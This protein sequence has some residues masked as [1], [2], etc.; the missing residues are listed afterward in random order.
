MGIM[1]LCL[2]AK[3][4]LESIEPCGLES[5]V[6]LDPW[7]CFHQSSPPSHTLG[8]THTDGEGNNKGNFIAPFYLWR[9]RQSTSAHHVP[10]TAA[11]SC[12]L[13]TDFPP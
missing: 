3:I 1:M 8:F 10:V 6:Q 7:V 11:F 2:T 4:L 13:N 5:R 9:S 12:W